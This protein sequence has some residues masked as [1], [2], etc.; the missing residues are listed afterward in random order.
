MKVTES[1]R[2]GSRPARLALG[3]A[4][5]AF[6][7]LVGL[8][9][10]PGVAYALSFANG[11]IATKA[12]SVPVGTYG[13]QCKPWAA[14]MVN[15]VLAANGIS[16]RVT[17]YYS[18]GAYYQAYLNGGGT[19]IA[20]NDVSKA[21]PGDLIQT[22]NPAQRTSDWPTTRGLHTAIVVARTSTVGTVVVRDSNWNL[23]Q[24]VREHTWTPVAWASARGAAA[25]LWRFGT[26]DWRLAYA[27]TI[28]QWSNGAGKPNTSWYVGTDLKRYWIP[29]AAV[30]WCLRNRGVRDLGVQTSTVLNAL[31]DQTGKWASC[32]T[33]KDSIGVNERLNRGQSLKSSDGRYTFVLQASDGNL[34]AYNSAGRAIWATNKLGGDFLILQGDSNL[35]VY[36]N[37]GRALWASNTV[38]SG[39]TRL[40]MQSDGNV[41]LY[42]ADGRPVWA[43]NTVGR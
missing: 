2:V 29:S 34:V 27:N 6:I 1:P 16:R 7:A 12:R 26:V 17:G 39:A 10:S 18:G 11:Q 13:G 30:Y 4:L 25:Y 3:A 15:S 14:S 43:S 31:P 35:V 32:T 23:D 9:V 28:V 42:R 33:Y 24:R 41:V 37:A 8:V 36:T 19:L 38:G 21:Q 40:Y 22:I 5:A 20:V